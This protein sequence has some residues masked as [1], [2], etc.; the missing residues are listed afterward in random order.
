ML[1][2]ITAISGLVLVLV[3]L[4]GYIAKKELKYVFWLISGI[5][6][7]VI[8]LA[9]AIMG[10][11]D[12][13]AFPGTIYLGSIYPSFLAIGILFDKEEKWGRYY[14]I[15]TL[16]ML[17]LIGAGQATGTVL[18]TIAQVTLHA[19]SGLIIVFLPLLYYFKGE[20]HEDYLFFSI[21]G[22]VIG[23]GGLALA[24]LIAGKPL[25]P[26]DLVVMLLHPLLFISAFL[27]ALSV[28]L[29]QQL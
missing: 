15:F 27:I 21:G 12:A 14:L 2:W 17:V 3:T 6:F 28:Y 13:L 16:I 11:N 5:S 23:I 18:K 10:L 1:E 9:L 25:L 26:F 7:L 8:G 20:L 22:I 19:T 29:V 4:M 24:T